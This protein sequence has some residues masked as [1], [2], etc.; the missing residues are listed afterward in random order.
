[1]QSSPVNASLHTRFVVGV[2]ALPTQQIFGE[3]YVI[4]RKT[5]VMH[6]KLSDILLYR[7]KGHKL[8]HPDQLLMRPWD[9]D[10]PTSKP[11]S[12]TLPGKRS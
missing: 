3:E 8:I 10:H 11:R 12:R 4:R 7:S 9:D 1:M 5:V 2:P 6:S